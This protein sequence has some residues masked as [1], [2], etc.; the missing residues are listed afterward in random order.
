MVIFG[1]RYVRRRTEVAKQSRATRTVGEVRIDMRMEAQ[2][3]CLEWC[4][5]AYRFFGSMITSQTNLLGD[6]GLLCT[7]KRPGET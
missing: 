6:H 2:A 4:L 3:A 5:F 1:L 7:P